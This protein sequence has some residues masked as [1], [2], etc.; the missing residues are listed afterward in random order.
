MGSAPFERERRHLVL[1]C[2]GIALG[3]A[4]AGTLDRATG[5]VILLA[6]WLGAVFALPR[7]GRAG[8]A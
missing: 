7:L 3:L 5:G 4:V 1:A 2:A 6:G 8:P